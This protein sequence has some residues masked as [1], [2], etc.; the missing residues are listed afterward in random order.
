LKHGWRPSGPKFRYLPNRHPA[1]IHVSPATPGRI[2]E[3]ALADCGHGSSSFPFSG[4][5]DP[6]SEIEETVALCLMLAGNAVGRPIVRKELLTTEYQ[7]KLTPPF[8]Y[9][10]WFRLEEIDEF[11]K[12]LHLGENMFFATAPTGKI[13]PV[14]DL[15]GLHPV[16][17]TPA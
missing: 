9:A 2:S 6:P 17:L 4:H 8:I 15:V 14:T 1:Q 3:P 10:G 11:S 16:R 7:E 13:Y 12:S 5:F